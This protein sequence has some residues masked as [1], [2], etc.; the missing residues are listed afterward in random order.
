MNRFVALARV[1]SREQGREGFSLEVQ[2]DALRRYAELQDGE[3]VRFYRIA[4][5]ASKSD[6]RTTFKELVRYAKKH[7]ME[8]DGLLFYK[9]DRA[10]EISTTTSNSNGWSRNTTSPSF[11]SPSPPTATLPVA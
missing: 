6:E 7:C 9:L 11:P 4:E 8:I 5:T 1:S 10:P 3:I 2:E